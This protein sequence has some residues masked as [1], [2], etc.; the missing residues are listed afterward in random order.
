MDL[1]SNHLENATSVVRA[2]NT[3]VDPVRQAQP[4]AREGLLALSHRLTAMVETPSETVQRIGWAES[5]RFAAIKTAV[6]LK[7]FDALNEAGGDS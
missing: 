5:A 2:M 7:I 3:L 1:S 4:G 6:D